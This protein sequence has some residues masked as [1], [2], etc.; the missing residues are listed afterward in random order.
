MGWLNKSTTGLSFHVLE[1]K[2]GILKE[3]IFKH[4]HRDLSVHLQSVKE[5]M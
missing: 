4:L 2:K 3:R 1:R 5:S